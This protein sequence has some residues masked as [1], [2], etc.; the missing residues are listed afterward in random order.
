[1]VSL[2]T[3]GSVSPIRI[4]TLV[5]HRIAMV[6]SAIDIYVKIYQRRAHDEGWPVLEVIHRAGDGSVIIALPSIIRGGAHGPHPAGHQGAHRREGTSRVRYLHAEPGQSAQHRPVL[7]P[8]PHA[9]DG[10]ATGSAAYLSSRRGEPLAEA[11]G[12]GHDL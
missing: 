7:A 10:A 8:P 1:M 4:R 3:S 11:A 9:R 12:A 6:S 5:R 2:A